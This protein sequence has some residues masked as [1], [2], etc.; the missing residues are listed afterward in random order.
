MIG[1]TY[2]KS[3][4]LEI[5]LNLIEIYRSRNISRQL[6]HSVKKEQQKRRIFE[7]CIRVEVFVIII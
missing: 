7:C 4:R 3:F 6:F 1:L 5:E 2:V